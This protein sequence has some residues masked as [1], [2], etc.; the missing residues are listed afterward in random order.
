LVDFIKEEDILRIKGVNKFP[1]RALGYLKSKYRLDNNNIS[2]VYFY[3]KPLKIMAIYFSITV[4]ERQNF[5][6]YN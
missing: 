4:E 5:K 2:S 6:E 1:Y 3:E